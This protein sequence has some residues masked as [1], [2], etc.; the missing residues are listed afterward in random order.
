M[1][2]KT[3]ILIFIWAV[4]LFSIVFKFT[5]Y[6][7]AAGPVGELAQKL[8]NSIVANPHSYNMYVILHPE[9]A[10]SQAT[11]SE[12]ER[13]QARTNN[14]IKIHLVFVK[15]KQTEHHENSKLFARASSLSDMSV[16]VDSGEI[17]KSLGALTSG[18]VLLYNP[19]ND[20]VF[21]GGVTQARG[22][23][24]PNDGAESIVN[25]VS[26][27]GSLIIQTPVYGCHLFSEKN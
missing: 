13:I 6:T 9:C 26:S 2:A 3:L 22:H 11:L 25:I 12:I 8:P 10:C 27:K 19:S 23:E 15:L 5:F 16:L 20:L 17:A 4:A 7:S 1:K 24:G 21:A 18:Q 14:Q